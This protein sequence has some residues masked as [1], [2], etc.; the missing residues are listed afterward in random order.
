MLRTKGRKGTA[1]KTV[2][3]WQVPLS[4]LMTFLGDPGRYDVPIKVQKGI[5]YETCLRI[6]L[7]TESWETLALRAMD[8]TE[9]ELRQLEGCRNLHLD[10]CVE[11]LTAQIWIEDLYL[12][13]SYGYE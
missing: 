9:G 1:I 2:A 7:M 5:S 4:G 11:R 6:F 10:H 8:V 3:D 13:R 12:E